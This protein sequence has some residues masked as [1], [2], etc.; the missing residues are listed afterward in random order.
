MKRKKK[1]KGGSSCPEGH[2]TPTYP[3]CLTIAEK[4]SDL[5]TE[6]RL[7]KTICTHKQINTFYSFI[8]ITICGTFT[9]VE[10]CSNPP[11]ICVTL[12][13]T[14]NSGLHQQVGLHFRQVLRNC[15]RIVCS[16]PAYFCSK[17]CSIT[18]IAYSR[19]VCFIF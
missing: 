5:C 11:D 7:C 17:N 15:L 18:S 8:F 10:Q 16:M 12:K 14:H 1:I 2:L 3:I 13:D 6:K 9:P 4:S 19:P